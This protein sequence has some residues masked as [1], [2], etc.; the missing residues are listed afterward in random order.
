VKSLLDC[1]FVCEVGNEV[2]KAVDSNAARLFPEKSRCGLNTRPTVRCEWASQA[3]WNV[4]QVRI[5]PVEKRIAVGGPEDLVYVGDECR[6]Q[7]LTT[8]GA[9]AGELPLTQNTPPVSAFPEAGKVSGVAVNNTGDV[10]VT[11]AAI[12]SNEFAGVPAGVYEYEPAGPSLLAEY[13]LSSVLV[14]GLALDPNGRL[15]LTDNEPRRGAVYQTTGPETGTRLSE[16]GIGLDE[17]EGLSFDSASHDLYAA[18]VSRHRIVVFNEVLTPDAVTG[19]VVPGSLTATSAS[20]KGEARANQERRTLPPLRSS[21]TGVARRSRN[22]N[23][24][25]LVKWNRPLPHRRRAKAMNPLPPKSWACS[26]TRFTTTGSRR[27]TRTGQ[28]TAKN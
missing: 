20:L 26:P 13:D 19:N 7:E 6:A 4:E 14:K 16:F 11:E 10:Y 25:P 3:T 15:I 1:R 5:L 22:A 21:N 28:A 27:R 23:R 18:N 17:M 12:G 9:W 24:P 8:Q 2:N